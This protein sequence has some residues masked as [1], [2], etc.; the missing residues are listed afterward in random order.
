[1]LV[2]PHITTTLQVS[3]SASAGGQEQEEQTAAVNS[4]TNILR[5]SAF[6]GD[7]EKI[8]EE[9]DSVEMASHIGEDPATTLKLEEIMDQLRQR[10]DQ[11]C[12]SLNLPD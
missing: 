7:D 11:V 8:E 3:S 12:A 1:M 4:N 9:K 2:A 6:I 5:Q 10:D